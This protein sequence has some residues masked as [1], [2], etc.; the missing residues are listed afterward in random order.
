M[1]LNPLTYALLAQEAYSSAPQIGCA[2]SAAR[3]IV[4]ATIDGICYAIPGTNNLACWLADLDCDVTVTP[5]GHLHGGFNRAA[6]SI[7]D[8]IDALIA[9]S[10]PVAAI[11][12]GHSE[13]AALALILAGYL[14]LRGRPPRAVFAFE[15][16]RVTIDDTLG[17]LLAEHG[18]P[19]LMTRCGNDLVPMVPRLVHPWRHPAPLK[20][21]GAAALPF[22]NVEDHLMA[23]V[24]EAVR[25][26][27][28]GSE[29]ATA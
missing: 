3:A 1:N 5:L 18:V 28:I 6:W 14:C 12:T 13:G 17:Q 25:A 19:I 2:G 27:V 24:V 11:L 22:P 9:D 23:R 4:E 7:V 26:F 29:L 21:I 15:P 8:E 10:A 20:P 16:P